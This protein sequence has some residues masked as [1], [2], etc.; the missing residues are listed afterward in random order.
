MAHNCGLQ[1]VNRLE[2]S[3]Y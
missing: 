3:C 1:Q 2:R